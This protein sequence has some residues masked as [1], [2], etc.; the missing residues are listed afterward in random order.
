M[1]RILTLLALIVSLAVSCTPKEYTISIDGQTEYKLSSSG[2]RLSVRV[3]TNAPSWTYVIND[4]PVWIT[5]VSSNETSLELAV[6]A[7]T[8]NDVRNATILLTAEGGAT[9]TV[10]VEQ[11][12]TPPEPQIT[13]EGS[14]E[15]PAGASGAQISVSTNQGGWDFSVTEGDTWL[16]AAASGDI[17]S[18][19]AA[20][21]TSEDV[22]TGRIRIYAPD[23]TS[24]TVFKDIAVSQQANVIFYDPVDLSAVGTANCYILEHRGEFSF[25]ARVAGNGLGVKGLSAP[26]ALNPAGVKLIWQTEPGMISDLRCEGGRI[27]FEASKTPGSAVIAALDGKG[28]IIWSWHIWHPAVAVESLR[29]QTGSLV[30]NMNLGALDNRESEI[31]SHGMLY[32]W[33]R[34]DPFPYSPVAK[35]GSVYTVP[36]SVYDSEGKTVK[37]GNSDRYSLKD[38]SLAFSIGNPDVCISN[39]AQSSS[40]K[41]WLT[42]KESSLALWGNPGGAERSGGKYKSEGSKSFYDPCP[43]GWRVPS[44]KEFLHFTKSGGYT[45][46]VGDTKDGLEFN[47]L[48]GAASVAVVDIDEDGK[49]TENDWRCGWWFW[50]DESAGIKS[51]F[52][53]ATR[54]DGG[55]AML[56][57]SMVGLWGNYW[58]NAASDETAPGTAIALAFSLKDYYQNYQITV[59]PVSSGAR[60]DAYS[61]RCIK[62]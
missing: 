58:T 44:V 18:I 9:A 32:Q 5:V 2:V 27:S 8:S 28:A 34:K 56:M 62:E 50:L 6:Q 39:S 60:A 24:Y 48:G 33:G 37:I 21:N 31:S 29:N 17:L 35:N 19:E 10:A 42:P 49:Y 43:P 15:L 41:D 11:E 26:S 16:T 57:G 55:Y 25:D 12:G 40:T 52:P 30:M 36:I 23:K 38:N 20:E 46:A 22:R 53:A 14:V 13:A 45:W 3:V 4:S 47:D 54:F 1:K 59:S 61:V 7:N 51:Y